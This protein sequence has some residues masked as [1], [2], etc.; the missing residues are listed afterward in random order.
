MGN[1]EARNSSG[2]ARAASDRAFGDP[3]K[4][5]AVPVNF[6]IEVEELV[7]KAF[8]LI[9][10][11]KQPHARAFAGGHQKICSASRSTSARMYGESASRVE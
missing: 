10:H 3:A 6:E 11:V 1:L 9:A 8:D 5:V 7:R 4:R 2:R